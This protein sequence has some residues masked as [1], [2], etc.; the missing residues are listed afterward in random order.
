ME[1]N[2]PDMGPRGKVKRVLA[3][4]RYRAY[5]GGRRGTKH[6]HHNSRSGRGPTFPKAGF[7]RKK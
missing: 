6:K 2:V 7:S 4:S 3:T 5:E 1:R